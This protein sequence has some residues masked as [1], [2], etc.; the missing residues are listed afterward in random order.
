MSP[1][2]VATLANMGLSCIHWAC[3]EC[4][5]YRLRARLGSLAYGSGGL[6]VKFLQGFL[7]ILDSLRSYRRMKPFSWVKHRRIVIRDFIR[8]GFLVEGFSQ[9]LVVALVLKSVLK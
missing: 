4:I 5:L 9:R 7:Q 8:F 1:S 2:V 3:K 6:R